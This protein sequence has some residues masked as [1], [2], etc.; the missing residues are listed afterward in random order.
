MEE[1]IQRRQVQGKVLDPSQGIVTQAEGERPAA[2]V[3]DPRI[4]GK[5]QV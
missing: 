3:H 5:T 1:T 2:L 4:A